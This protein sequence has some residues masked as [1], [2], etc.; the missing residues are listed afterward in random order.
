MREETIMRIDRVLSMISLSLLSACVSACA[1][2]ATRSHDEAPGGD[3]HQKDQIAP[4]DDP[5]IL[6]PGASLALDDVIMSSDV[7]QTFG[8]DDQHVPYPDTYWPFV[9]EGS[10]AHWNGA[11]AS[12]I[13]KLLSLTNPDQK[14][15]AKDWEHNNHGSGVP[16]VAGWWGHCPGWTGAAMSNAPILHAVYAKAD[17]GGGVTS[18]NAGDDG[19]TRFEIGDVNAL[20]AEIYV[21]GDSTF[22]GGR[23]DTKPSDIKRDEFGRIVRDGTGCKGVNAGALLVALASRMKGAHQALAIDA[24]NDFNTDQ[25]WNQPAYRYTVYRYQPLNETQAANL[26]AHGTFDGDQTKYLWDDAARGW[27]LVDLGIDWV[28][29]YG[30]NTDVVSGLVST[31]ETR[32]VAVIELDGDPSAH[33][34]ILGGEYV[35]DPSVGADRLTVPPFL[36]I[37]NGPGGDWGDPSVNGD[38]HNP[39]VSVGAVQQLI[40]LGQTSS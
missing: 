21:D 7:G 23:C 10:D 1:A 5:T 11:D 27:A 15:A 2:N 17:G 24:Q 37:S 39:Y 28:S 40:A 19:C 26:V 18:C 9:N 14:Q 29:E 13:E 30:A 38:Y 35:D 3:R 33:P 8:T 16:N 22:I 31:N 25:I 4:S 6:V 36:W 32:V 20:M 34:T 12:P